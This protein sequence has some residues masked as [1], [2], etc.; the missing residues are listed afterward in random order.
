MF[1]FEKALSKL[2]PIPEIVEI[3][4]SISFN[5]KLEILVTD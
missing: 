3:G 4:V 2:G 5:F 1:S